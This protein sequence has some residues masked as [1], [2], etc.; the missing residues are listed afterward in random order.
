MNKSRSLILELV[1]AYLTDRQHNRSE[2]RPVTAR[3]VTADIADDRSRGAFVDEVGDVMAQ[4]VET[5]AELGDHQDPVD[6]WRYI[7]HGLAG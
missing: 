3:H 6:L 5:I 4:L 7:T 2:L 1:S